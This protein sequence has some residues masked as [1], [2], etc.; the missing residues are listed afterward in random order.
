MPEAQSDDPIVRTSYASAILVSSFL[1]VLTLAWALYDEFFGLR[2]WRSYQREFSAVYEKY[3]QRQ[4]PL[5]KV[6]LQAVED[7]PKY[8]QLNEAY[9]G[10]RAAAK[11]R[12]DQIDAETAFVNLLRREGCPLQ[13]VSARM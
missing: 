6:A 12:L 9:R 5:Q 2:P 11:P 10:A 8:R 13:V 4:I 3:L 1:L 7:S